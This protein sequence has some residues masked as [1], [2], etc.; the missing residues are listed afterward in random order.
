MSG[1]K[2]YAHF[3]KEEDIDQLLVASIKPKFDEFMDKV[4]KINVG[5]ELTL[6]WRHGPSG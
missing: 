2:G 4:D 3:T 5:L 6:P 1:W